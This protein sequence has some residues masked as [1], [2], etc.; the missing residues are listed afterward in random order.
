MTPLPRLV[1]RTPYIF[2][3]AAVFFFFASYA[4]SYWELRMGMA[5]AEPGNPMAKFFMMKGLYQAALEACYIAGNGVMIH[6]LL[7]IWQDGTL[8]R[9]DGGQP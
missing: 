1:Q 2:Y 3:T 6:I 4:L 5:Y 7:A 8:R 9:T